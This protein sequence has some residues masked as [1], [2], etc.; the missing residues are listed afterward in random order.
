MKKYFLILLGALLAALPGFSQVR[1]AA[2]TC[3][4]K[5][6]FGVFYRAKLVPNSEVAVVAINTACRTLDGR[7]VYHIVGTGRVQPFFRWFFDL[8]D[9]YTS[10]LDQKTLRPL[11]FNA[12]LREGGY[13]FSHTMTYDWS[14]MKADSRYRNL[15]RPNVKQKTLPL[16]PGA[17]DAVGLFYNI[18][19]LPADSF[20]PGQPRTLKV[21]LEDTVRPMQYR[22]LGREIR[23][24][25]GV[26]EFR[27][28]KFSMHLVTSSGESFEDGSE[29]FLWVSDDLNHIPLYI[30]S[31][32]R[33]GSI[34][35]RIKKFENLKYPL[36]SRIK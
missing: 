5:L 20:T 15:K 31:P 17:S 30:E 35:V 34:S 23:S 2:F 6:E 18:R 4:E 22:F 19:S 11:K 29:L 14:T 21:V 10:W 16:S 25:K 24:I 26:G 32:I 8:N 12:E 27:T 1:E 28:L 33:V 7:D 9:T 13:R 3:G 36:D